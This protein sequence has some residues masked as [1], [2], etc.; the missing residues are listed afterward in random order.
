ML[1]RAT[2]VGGTLWDR[3]RDHDVP[4]ALRIQI[5]H[6]LRDAIGGYRAPDPSRIKTSGEASVVV[7]AG[8]ARPEVQAAVEDAQQLHL[9][10]LQPS[11]SASRA[12]PIWPGALRKRYPGQSIVGPASHFS[13]ADLP[14]S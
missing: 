9:N 2:S 11:T 10:G 5:L 14:F 12:R 3:E 4:V 1:S 7:R 8:R 13:A 6:L